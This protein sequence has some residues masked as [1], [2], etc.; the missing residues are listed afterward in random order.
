MCDNC[1]NP[2]TVQCNCIDLKYV[3]YL[4]MENEVCYSNYKHK[5]IA[6]FKTFCKLYSVKVDTFSNFELVDKKGD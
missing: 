2:D 4:D 6:D 1:N 3:K 5:S